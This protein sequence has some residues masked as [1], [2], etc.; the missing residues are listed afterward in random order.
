VQKLNSFSNSRNCSG[1]FSRVVFQKIGNII[2]Y[3]IDCAA[4]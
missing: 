3:K 4:F 2:R 1:R